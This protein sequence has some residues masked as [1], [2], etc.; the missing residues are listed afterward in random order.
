MTVEILVG[1]ALLT[2]CL[3]V[4]V[5]YKIVRRQDDEIEALR[6]ANIELKDRVRILELM[7][8]L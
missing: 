3:A 2:M 6:L 1:A 8:S 7:E 5:L 4:W